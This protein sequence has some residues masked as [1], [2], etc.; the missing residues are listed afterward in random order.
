MIIYSAII[1]ALIISFYG[2]F[3]IEPAMKAFG[4]EGELLRYAVIYGKLLILSLPAFIL[5]FMFQTLFITA[6]KPNLGL[7]ITLIAGCTNMFLDYIFIGRMSL[8]LQGAAYAT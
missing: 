2:W 6:G 5:Q 1:L 4:A 3:L 8:G 7:A